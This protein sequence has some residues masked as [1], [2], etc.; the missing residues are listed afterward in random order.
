MRLNDPFKAVPVGGEFRT[1]L[2]VVHFDAEVYN[3]SVPKAETEV[4]DNHRF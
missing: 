3:D 2:F 1:T 4:P